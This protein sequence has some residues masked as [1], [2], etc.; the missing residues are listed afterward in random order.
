MRNGYKINW[1]K[2]SHKDIQNII[3]Y[4]NQNWTE[5]EIKRFFKKF[6]RSISSIQTFPHAFPASESNPQIRKCVISRLNSLYYSVNE[7]EIT[8]LSISD[9]RKK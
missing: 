9:N 2:E 4:L 1:S 5:R 7:T 8:I 3:Q 6:E